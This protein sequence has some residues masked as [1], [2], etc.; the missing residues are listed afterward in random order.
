MTKAGST[1]SDG[2]ASFA[3]LDLSGKIII[4]AS[5]GSE[6]RRMP[7]H[8]EEITYD[9]LIL[10]MQRVFKG[11][12]E[13][14]DA[15]AIK[16]KDEDGD[17][18]TIADNND[19]A[20]AIQCSRVLKIT[21]F[22]NDQPQPLEPK[23]VVTIRRELQNIRDRTNYLLD[24][25]E[26]KYCS[27]SK[28]TSRIVE[29]D[30]RK[31]ILQNGSPDSKRSAPSP[32]KKDPPREFDPLSEKKGSPIPENR[33][34]SRS[35]SIN[36]GS[37]PQNA[38]VSGLPSFSEQH[39]QQNQQPA[40]IQ[41]TVQQFQPQMP[42]NQGPPFGQQQQQPQSPQQQPPSTKF[43]VPNQGPYPGQGFQPPIQQQVGQH[44]QAGRSSIGLPHLNQ[45][46]SFA[47][48]GVTQQLPQQPQGYPGPQGPPPSSS[49]QPQGSYPGGPPT[50]QFGQQQPPMSGPPIGPPTPGPVHA[51][52]PPTSG[53][54]GQGPLPTSMHG[55][56][57][58]PPTSMYGQQGPPPSSQGY[59]GPQVPQNQGNYGQGAPQSG[60]IGPP[61][62]G[63]APPGGF[64]SGAANPYARSAAQPRP[65]SYR[66]PQAPG[67]QQ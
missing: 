23:E 40:T 46:P 18:V 3:H 6:I 17:L 53:F 59:L 1:M 27:G 37:R 15:V 45:Q 31:E 10:M 61:P 54:P 63:V 2:E 33:P 5:L 34:A 51:G 48:P 62:M 19:L 22:V 28:G 67:F 14:S 49:Y 47:P 7:I 55:Q 42:G 9:E 13:A 11:K 52:P 35:S 56:Q 64:A 26:G 21:L 4:K 38:P 44:P 8:N 36:L 16:Y 20:F 12:L 39:G 60:P 43:P 50:S 66:Y 58:P 41:A 32:V 24:Q 25:L 65:A 57:G 29:E 30:E